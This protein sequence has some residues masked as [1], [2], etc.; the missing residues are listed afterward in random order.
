MCRLPLDLMHTLT[1][2]IRPRV[3]YTVPVGQNPTGSV[4][5]SMQRWKPSLML[6]PDH[7]TRAQ[8]GH[9]R[10]LR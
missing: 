6:V 4:S 5:G 7:G 8:T 1:L 9:L 2:K 10:C 3:M